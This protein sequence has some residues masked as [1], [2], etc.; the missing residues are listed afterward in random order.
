M[1]WP[2]FGWL[3]NLFLGENEERKW[4]SCTMRVNIAKFYH[5]YTSNPVLGESMQSFASTWIGP[6]LDGGLIPRSSR[7]IGPDTKL[8]KRTLDITRFLFISLLCNPKVFI[9]FYAKKFHSKIDRD[10]G[11][12]PTYTAWLQVWRGS[13][14]DGMVLG[15]LHSLDNG[16]LGQSSVDISY[17]LFQCQQLLVFQAWSQETT[18]HQTPMM[19]NN[20]C[21]KERRKEP[22]LTS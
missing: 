22:F 12:Y 3:L 1:G 20:K 17:V 18:F 14:H 9:F 6:R 4:R 21:A 16:F 8:S 10:Y 15:L 13:F 19:E 2:K 7:S 11:S 5:F